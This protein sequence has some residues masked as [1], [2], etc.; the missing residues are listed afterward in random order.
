MFRNRMKKR[1]TFIA[2][3]LL[4]MTVAGCGNNAEETDTDQ[5]TIAEETTKENIDNMDD[6]DDT[7]LEVEAN[8]AGDTEITDEDVKMIE[9]FLNEVI[10]SVEGEGNQ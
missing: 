10:D 7:D 9:D 3:A 6:T 1:L 4:S 8:A 2:I 5:N